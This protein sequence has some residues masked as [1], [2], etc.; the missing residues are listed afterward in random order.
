MLEYI[1][2]T[3]PPEIASRATVKLDVD[4]GDEIGRIEIEGDTTAVAAVKMLSDGRGHKLSESAYGWQ[5]QSAIEG[6][7]SPTTET[8]TKL[9]VEVVSQLDSYEIPAVE[10]QQIT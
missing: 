9:A 7:Q 4:S 10:P 3:L 1:V 6:S 5:L 8:A 2:T